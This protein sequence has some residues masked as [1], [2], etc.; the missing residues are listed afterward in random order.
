LLVTQGLS[1]SSAR[2]RNLETDVF[3]SCHCESDSP[4]SAVSDTLVH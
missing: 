4:F 3:L 2:S 1:R